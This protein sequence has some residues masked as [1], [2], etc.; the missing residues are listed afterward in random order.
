IWDISTGRELFSLKAQN[1]GVTSVE[2]S[3][4]GQHLASTHSGLGS[5]FL[6]DASITPELQQ[7]R[8]A[9]Q[10]VAGLFRQMGLR[11]DVLQR[12]RTMPGI[13]PSRRQAALDAAQRCPENPWVL[14]D[15]VKPGGER[16]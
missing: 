16:T 4:D 15:L 2:F 11:A 12:L 13:S 9:N 14:N 6:W 5:I 7:R 3:P 1:L 8:A 10:L